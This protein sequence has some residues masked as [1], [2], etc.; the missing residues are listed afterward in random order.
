VKV[1]RRAVSKVF[2][3]VV[4]QQEHGQAEEE[5]CCYDQ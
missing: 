2:P 5:A 1:K 3:A 4:E